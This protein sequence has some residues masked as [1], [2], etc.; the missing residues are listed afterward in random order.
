MAMVLYIIYI[1]L[2]INVISSRYIID[3]PL[4]STRMPIPCQCCRGSE[5]FSCKMI[6]M[7]SDD[8]RDLWM[9]QVTYEFTLW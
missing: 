3:N 6:P 8:C 4:V 7:K 1:L 9:G 2:F 5:L